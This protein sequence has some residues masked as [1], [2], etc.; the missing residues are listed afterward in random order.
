V[1]VIILIRAIVSCYMQVSYGVHWNVFLSFIIS[2]S[3]RTNVI[4]Y[5][6]DEREKKAHIYCGAAHHCWLEPVDM[7]K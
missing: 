5:V 4:F 7:E 1:D 3:P 2:L 6:L